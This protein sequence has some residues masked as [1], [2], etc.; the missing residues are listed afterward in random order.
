MN[1]RLRPDDPVRARGLQME[2]LFAIRRRRRDLVMQ[3]AVATQG[4][5]A[6]RL[7][8]HDNLEVMWAIRSA[9]TTTATAIRTASLAVGRQAGLDG[10]R[11]DLLETD[12]WTEVLRALD[13]VEDRKRVT[14]DV[15]AARSP[16]TV[17]DS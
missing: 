14:L 7:I 3:L 1:E 5:S 8:E 12:A 15:L 2:A 4:Y 11:D 17:D 10:S 9:V 13:T 16:G 6:L